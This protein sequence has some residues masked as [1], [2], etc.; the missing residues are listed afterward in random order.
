M[1]TNLQPS[2]IIVGILL[3][4]ATFYAGTRYQ[5]GVDAKNQTAR[6]AARGTGQYPQNGRNGTNRMMGGFRP[7]SGEVLSID[8]K[9]M[10]VKVSDGS[11]KNVYL[12]DKL[13][14]TK[15]TKAAVSDIKI[16]SSVAAF[17]NEGS[18]GSL[19]ASTIQLDPVG[20]F[21]PS[22]SPTPTTSK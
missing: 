3:C 18:D 20:M 16:G 14:V 22:T 21:K 15:T 17:G 4:G 10:T 8:S 11:S 2:I 5:S 19:T 6:Y 12:S 1:K 7:V 13:E 9:L